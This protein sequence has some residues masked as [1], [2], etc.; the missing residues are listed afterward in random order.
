MFQLRFNREDCVGG[1]VAVAV[2][3]TCECS[4][5]VGE[6][7]EAWRQR[8]GVKKEDGVDVRALDKRDGTYEGTGRIDFNA[9]GGVAARALDDNLRGADRREKGWEGLQAHEKMTLTLPS[10]ITAGRSPSCVV[11]LTM[12]LMG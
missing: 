12:A 8:E 6:A 3:V 9:N 10:G 2:L 1:E 5:A 11:P 4:E 7:V